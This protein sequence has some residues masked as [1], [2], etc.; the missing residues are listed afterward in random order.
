MKDLRNIVLGLLAL[1]AL[2][3]A[4]GVAIEPRLIMDEEETVATIPGLPVEW[5]GEWVALI[6]DLQIG[7]R[8]DNDGMVRRIVEER[9]AVALIGEDFLYQPGENP[10]HEIGRAVELLRP[11]AEA[12]IP[13]YAVL[14]NHD[15]AMVRPDGNADYELARSVASALEEDGIRVLENEAVPLALAGS[16]D[17][18]GA[19]Y[20]LGTGADWPGEDRP[21]VALAEV[22]N[23]VPRI[24]MMHNP[25]T[26][27][28]F[29]A[30]AAPF[31]VAGHTHGGQVRV[32]FMPDWS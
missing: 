1:A 25:D 23:G 26:F 32:P 17:G 6:A 27:A 29:P 9:R 20:L 15:Y 5:E 4:W 21:P 14:G 19:L 12:G 13:T 18:A 10:M 7:M 30:G 28:E 22:P 31:A 16:Q 3:L 8:L 24:A 11:L 2:L